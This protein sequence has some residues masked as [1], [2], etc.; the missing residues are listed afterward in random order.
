MSPSRLA[1]CAPPCCCATVRLCF[2]RRLGGSSYA[3]APASASWNSRPAKSVTGV[4]VFL[5]LPANPL[6]HPS[7]S[8]DTHCR[9]VQVDPRAFPVLGA[10]NRN[11]T[12]ETVLT[13]LRR[14]MAQPHNRKQPQPPEGAT[15]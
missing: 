2:A 15:Y 12:M 13:E 6:H 3:S 8:L 10:W 14:E 11:Y 4:P 9:G 1:A 5:V 7:P